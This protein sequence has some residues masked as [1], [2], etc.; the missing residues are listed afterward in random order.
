MGSFLKGKKGM[1]LFLAIAFLLR[2][3][4][5][6]FGTLENDFRTFL[7]WSYYVEEYGFSKF[8]SQWSDYLPGYI[9][10]LWVLRKLNIVFSQI[11]ST[12]LYKLPAI[13][14]DLGVGLFIY[15]AVSQF[16]KKWALP[17]M[18]IYLFNPAVFANSA[19]WGQIDGITSFFGVSSIFFATR[20]PL[21]SS[22]SLSLGTLIK[23]QAGFLA[24]LLF[25]LWLKNFGF[26]KALGSTLV[27]FAIFLEGFVLFTGD[28]QVL[29][30]IIERLGATA[31]QYPYT[32]VN[33]FNFWGLV[34]GFWKP[35]TN[36]Q[37]VGVFVTVLIA[38]TILFKWFFAKGDGIPQKFL[39]ASFIFLV[40]FLFLTRM[41]ERHLLP[42]LAP[43][44]IASVSHPLLWV[45]F[46][47]LSVT[48]LVNLRWA[49][50]GGLDFQAIPPKE[51]IDVFIA[52]NLIAAILMALVLL[53][54]RIGRSLSAINH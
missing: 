18:V 46:I 14:A 54:P 34:H 19:L 1:W 15:K 52:V 25:L 47:A 45:A 40:S 5:S 21:M 43:L 7:A 44:V 42:T 26:K 29:Q 16:N 51:L 13:L 22:V 53:K 2:I 33:A 10:I 41:H 50:W 32:S 4:L 30:F 24:P 9:Y 36:W 35:D 8:Y 11:P 12:L 48:Y 3:F 27:A 37:I 20:F 17:A 49:G 6:P 31:G 28:K 38:S 39:L 23:P